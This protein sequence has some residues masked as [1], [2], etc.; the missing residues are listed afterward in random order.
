MNA[1]AVY[2]MWGCRSNSAGDRC[3]LES[4]RDSSSDLAAGSSSTGSSSGSCLEKIALHQDSVAE[5]PAHIRL[6]A[7]RGDAN[8]HVTNA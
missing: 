3:G 6:R 5:A 7:K 2:K 1:T 4:R 8:V